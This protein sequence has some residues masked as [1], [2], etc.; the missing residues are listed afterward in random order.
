MF[1]KVAAIEAERELAAQKAKQV[2]IFK[3]G[4]YMREALHL[5]AAAALVSAVGVWVG[6]L[7]LAGCAAGAGL[8]VVGGGK[9][10][11]KFLPKILKRREVD[12][13]GA[14]GLHEAVKE[15]TPKMRLPQ[16]PSLHDFEID[17]DEVRKH[18]DVT[19][20][21]AQLQRVFNAAATGLTR[22][23]IIVSE[24]L[25]QGL[26]KEET[27]A[28]VAHEFAHLGGD[29]IRLG[30]VANWLQM[31]TMFAA[32]FG[33]GGAV[34]SEGWMTGLLSIGGSV[35]I[36]YGGSKIMP[37]KEERYASDGTLKPGAMRRQMTIWGAQEA[38]SIGILAIPN[39]AAVLTAVA[40]EHGYFWAAQFLNKSLSRRHEFQ[41]DRG[42]VAM[43]GNPLKLIT[44]L[45]KL[46]A[47]LQMNDP[48]LALARDWRRGPWY[49]RPVKLVETLFKSHPDTQRRCARLA[50]M[51][52]KQGYSDEE[53]RQ[54]LTAPIDI[55]A[56]KERVL[57]AEAVSAALKTE[58]A[59]NDT[60]SL[61][62]EANEEVG[63][64]IYKSGEEIAAAAQKVESI[65]AAEIKRKQEARD[66][67]AKLEAEQE[68]DRFFAEKKILKHLFKK[69]A[70]R[71]EPAAA[72]PESEIR[73]IPFRDI[74]SYVRMKERLRGEIAEAR[75]VAAAEM[76]D[77]EYKAEKLK[78][79]KDNISFR[80]R[81]LTRT[82]EE[83]EKATRIVEEPVQKIDPKDR[84]KAMADRAEAL[85]AARQAGAV[86]PSV[87]EKARI[88]AIVARAE[89][90]CKKKP[91]GPGV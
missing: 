79:A 71:K 20:N 67:K 69:A 29:H 58:A 6:P 37:R 26:E 88:D 18:S 4:D 24:A 54:A 34:V 60:I 52:K 43:G 44:S 89:E 14:E 50:A 66:A 40:I 45:R 7:T 48:A 84:V 87:E 42:A 57:K 59:L 47:T 70:G 13:R 2:R 63:G 25:M 51:G 68:K 72:K 28:V 22:P 86:K 49:S 30:M 16:E 90:R 36:A 27:R 33:L 12:M 15:F 56:L 74:V 9:L 91:Q 46:E 17:M 53:I 38:L 85:I 82:P 5:G 80:V 76:A 75:K 65:I 39:P 64:S 8:L 1:E 23:V 81:F 31:T 77:A 35:A 11:D 83:M 73:D 41:A 78:A 55:A 3:A 61:L 10:S 62:T 21:P 19:A 32:M